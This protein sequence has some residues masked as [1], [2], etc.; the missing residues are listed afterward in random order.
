ML[1]ETVRRVR[2]PYDAV[3]GNC[4]VVLL[5]AISCRL[6]QPARDLVRSITNDVLRFSRQEQHGD[7]T[8]IIAKFIDTNSLTVIRADSIRLSTH[9][10]W[11]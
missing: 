11:F 4:D 9:S 7:I 5:N 8:L 2:E 1:V 10:R 3:C 6:S